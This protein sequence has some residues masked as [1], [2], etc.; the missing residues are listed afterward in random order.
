MTKNIPAKRQ[1]SIHSFLCTSSEADINP[2][3]AERIEEPRIDIAP[4]SSTP[5]KKQLVPKVEYGGEPATI[6]GYFRNQNDAAADEAEERYSWMQSPKDKNLNE[7]GSP[8]YDAS[9]IY[10]PPKQWKQFTPFEEQYWRIKC[11]LYDTVVFFKKG[12][13]Y[14]LYENDAELAASYFD[15]KVSDRVNMKMAGVPEA[16][17]DY[18]TQK[19][20]ACGFKVAK[21]D[22]CENSIGKE[23]RESQGS[24]KKKIIQREMSYI[25]SPGTTPFLAGNGMENNCLLA[26]GPV[27]ERLAAVIFFPSTSDAHSFG[28]FDNLD[29]IYDLKCR[30]DPCETVLDTLL[31]NTKVSKYVSNLFPGIACSYVSGESIGELVETYL[32][33]LN[34]SDKQTIREIPSQMNSMGVE[35]NS[36]GF[37]ISGEAIKEISL[38]DYDTRD[39]IFKRVNFCLSPFGKRLLLKW[40][41]FSNI[42]L[43][44]LRHRQKLLQA[45]LSLGYRF[46]SAVEEHLKGLPD[47]DRLLSSFKYPD[48]HSQKLSQLLL[49]LQKI[50]VLGIINCFSRNWT[51]SWAKPDTLAT[52]PRSTLAWQVRRLRWS[53]VSFRRTTRT[54]D[55]SMS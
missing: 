40:L 15:L 5:L 26:V 12:K 53:K 2:P 22:Q 28:P 18:W 51:S 42:T 46:S 23:I 8:E 54:T 49:G 14:E 13:F 3:D 43:E 50:I 31:K 19:F 44:T 1:S 36:P 47:L 45:S 38:V 27:G 7:P 52:G 48:F 6:S 32:K 16:T 29:V 30:F 24:E 35:S 55:P 10:I 21:V 34:V 37:E 11:D 20:L 33:K 9:S 4:I 41:C 39:N 17:V 25:M